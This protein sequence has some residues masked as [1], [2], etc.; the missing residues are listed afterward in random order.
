MTVLD[1]TDPYSIEELLA[2]DPLDLTEED[3]DTNTKLLVSALRSERREW[4]EAQLKAKVT[5]KRVAGNT[6]KKA[7]KKAAKE[8]II[9]EI[10]NSSVKI[11]LT[12]IIP[13]A[14]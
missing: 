14:Q 1:Q 12:K 2:R 7:Q 4:D 9:E 5:G 8:T 6:V 3:I 13:K 10:K 11:D